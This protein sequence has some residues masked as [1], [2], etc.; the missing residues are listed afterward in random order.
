M[1]Q[2][3]QMVLESLNEDICRSKCG[4]YLDVGTDVLT[5]IF[6]FAAVIDKVFFNTS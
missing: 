2:V 3:G 6:T 5:Y 1:G 4:V